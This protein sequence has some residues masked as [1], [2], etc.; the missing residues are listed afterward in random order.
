MIPWIYRLLGFHALQIEPQDVTKAAGALLRAG[1][2]AQITSDGHMHVPHHRLKRTLAALSDCQVTVGPL[3]GALGALYRVRHRYGLFAAVL[4]TLVLA[5]LSGRVVW[6]VRVEGDLTVEEAVLLQELSDG[7]LYAGALWNELSFSETEARILASSEH[8]AWLSIDRRGNVAYVSIVERA[9]HDEPTPPPYPYGNIVATQDAV[10]DEILVHAG[11]AT[12]KK[13]DTVRAGDLLISGVLPSEAGGGLCLADGQVM[14]LVEDTVS[15]LVPEQLPL[16][17][18]KERHLSGLYVNFFG[19]SLNILK[20]DGNPSDTC[21]IIEETTHV[22]LFGRYRLPITLTR[23]YTTE[24]QTV[25]RTLSADEM[26]AL[27]AEHLS[28]AVRARV[29]DGDLV[30]IRTEGAF[31][32]SGYVMTAY[33]VYRAPIGTLSP[34]LADGT[35]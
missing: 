26:A 23:S 6:D 13:G 29:A 20:N 16:L 19:F 35:P 28:E 30:R 22:R 14:G 12:V 4:T 7:G 9:V 2:A 21:A 33:L 18:T 34:L 17:Q 31:T 1:I 32:E 24:E 15:V 25:E 5:L 8:I 11:V 3:R 27:A 10:I